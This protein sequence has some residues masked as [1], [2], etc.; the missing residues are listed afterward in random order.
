MFKKLNLQLFA[1]DPKEES[2]KEEIE[3][4][5]ESKEKKETPKS[6]DDVGGML[7]KILDAVTKPAEEISSKDVLQVPAPKKPKLNPEEEKEQEKQEGGSAES[8][9][10]KLWKAIWR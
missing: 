2:A 5:D 10:T 9:G 3:K 7:K 4:P 1:K 6:N 8:W